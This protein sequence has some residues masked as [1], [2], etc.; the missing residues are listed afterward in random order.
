MNESV[1]KSWKR[2]SVMEG[3]VKAKKAHT[4]KRCGIDILKGDRYFRLVGEYP[5]GSTCIIH[6]CDEECK[7]RLEWS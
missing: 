1:G 3:W 7:G 4:C 2:K 5:N 6:C